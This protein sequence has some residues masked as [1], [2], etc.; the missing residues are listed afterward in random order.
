MMIIGSRLFCQHTAVN[1]HV[2]VRFVICSLMCRQKYEL[3]ASYTSVTHIQH[4]GR[5]Y[6]HNEVLSYDGHQVKFSV[7]TEVVQF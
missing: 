6:K 3:A 2:E 1:K 4:G 7:N 5:L